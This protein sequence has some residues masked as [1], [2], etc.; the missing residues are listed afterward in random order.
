MMP[1][2]RA[3]LLPIIVRQQRR[4]ARYR[5]AHPVPAETVA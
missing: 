2:L 3:V 5:D 4:L 1:L